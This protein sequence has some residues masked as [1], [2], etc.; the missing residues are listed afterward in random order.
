M[1]KDEVEKLPL[2][3]QYPLLQEKLPYVRLAELP[4]PVQKLD[5][6]AL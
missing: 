3:V 4:T 1:A 5:I 6:N 2:F